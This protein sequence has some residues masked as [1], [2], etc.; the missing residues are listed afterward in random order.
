[1]SSCGFMV[2]A[3]VGLWGGAKDTVDLV[4]RDHYSP[5]TG[6]GLDT[7]FAGLAIRPGAMFAAE[8]CKFCE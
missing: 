5:I 6:D 3:F 8:L 2:S 7:A 4:G 1:M